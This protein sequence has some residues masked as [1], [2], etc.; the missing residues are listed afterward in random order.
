MAQC[1][2]LSTLEVLKRIRYIMKSGRPIEAPNPVQ[3][4]D[5]SRVSTFVK[6]AQ[7]VQIFVGV[8]TPA[9]TYVVHNSRSGCKYK[10]IRP[11]FWTLTETPDNSLET[12]H[13]AFC[14]LGLQ[15]P[16]CLAIGNIMQHQLSNNKPHETRSIIA[17]TICLF[18]KLL[19]MYM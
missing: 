9:I 11:P 3:E 5:D 6:Y 13:A 16:D 7:N 1:I 12:K 19:Y 2:M 4:R 10:R 18:V 8:T 14:V 17:L 15:F